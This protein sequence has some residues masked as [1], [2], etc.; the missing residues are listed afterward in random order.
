MSIFTFKLIA[1][2]TMVLDHVKY[3]IPE[4]RN[5]VTIYFGRMAFP[6]F[7][8]LLGEG[9][10]HTSNLKKYYKRFIIFAL[11]S[12]IPFMLFR[13]L[14]GQWQMLNILFT[15]LLSLVAITIF[16]KLGKRYA[17]SLPIVGLIAYLGKLLNVDYGWYG[18][19][20]GFVLS[21][22]RTHQYSR[23]FAFATLNLIY[24]NNR[25]FFEF[26]NQY[27]I[28]YLFA[29]LPVVLLLFYNGKLGRKTKYLYYLFYP[30]HMLILYGIHLIL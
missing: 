26:P 9:Y 25:L 6:L 5:F 17:I 16:D 21:V 19:M 22:F 14:V 29:T 4:T 3:A 12:Q 2:L 23:I 15:L 18:V 11:I 24:Y 28:S 27:L 8:F 13:S 30:V 7:A 20:A 10:A 1:C